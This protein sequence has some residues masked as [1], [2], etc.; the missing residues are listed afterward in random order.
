M[1]EKRL[2]ALFKKHHRV[3]PRPRIR[4]DMLLRIKHRE[5]KICLVKGEIF[6]FIRTAIVQLFYYWPKSQKEKS[7]FVSVLVEKVK[8]SD[9]EEQLC[10][11]LD[12]IGKKILVGED[13]RDT[14]AR[15]IHRK[16]QM[17]NICIRRPRP[18]KTEQRMSIDNRF[19]GL[20]AVEERFFFSLRM[21]R[22]CF[23]PEGYTCERVSRK[24]VLKK[25]HFV[26]LPADTLIE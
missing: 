23:N 25:S 18:I 11:Q 24:G 12:G 5:M 17:R 14:A 4:K 1:T 16:L 19:G 15:C 8:T 10:S 6:V 2:I 22:R 3:V 21:P 13:P 26:W 7:S 20:P 9:G